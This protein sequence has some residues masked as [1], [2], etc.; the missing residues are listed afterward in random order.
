MIEH[1]NDIARLGVD[2]VRPHCRGGSKTTLLVG[3]DL[4]MGAQFGDQVGNVAD[5]HAWPAVQDE[6]SSAFA[7][8][9]S[10]QASTLDSY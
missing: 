3:R 9:M 6:N 8:G 2:V 5:A 10:V 4:V 7:L 1:G